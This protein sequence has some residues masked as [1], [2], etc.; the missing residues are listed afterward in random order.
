M[1][2]ILNQQLTE[3]DIKFRF[4]T[5]AIES[6]GWDKSSIRMEYYF[7]KGRIFVRGNIKARKKG[8]KADYILYTA[9]NYPIAVI[10]AKDNN[11]TA[12]HG[13]QQA[14]DYAEILDIPFA[15]S[16]NGE[17]FVEH[18]MATGKE[19]VI[20]MDQFPTPLELRERYKA[21]KSLSEQEQKIIEI[22]YDMYNKI[23]LEKESKSNKNN[24]KND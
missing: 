1:P 20:E 10:E 13:I 18:D 15:Y 12:A 21:S 22:P 16:S 17:S 8:K 4:I 6:K 19:R 24:K 23:K 9:E 14:I 7:T 3:E 5:P 2:N 11:H